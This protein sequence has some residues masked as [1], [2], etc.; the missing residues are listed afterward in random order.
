MCTFL[1]IRIKISNDNARNRRRK[2]PTQPSTYLYTF[3]GAECGRTR[4]ITMRKDFSSIMV[5]L[6]TRLSLKSS[7]YPRSILPS[8]SKHPRA[9]T[10]NEPTLPLPKRDEK[11]NTTKNE[12]RVARN[13][14]KPINI[15]QENDAHLS[16]SFCIR[17]F[18]SDHV[19]QCFVSHGL[20]RRSRTP[21]QVLIIIER[22]RDAKKN[23]RERAPRAR[24][25]SSP[26][27]HPREPGSAGLCLSPGISEV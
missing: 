19:C 16:H 22:K 2:S 23:T 5:I 17:A 21:F 18:S 13:P 12:M 6:W 11:Q 14:K 27:L 9:C 10:K 20:R 7:P 25:V 15:F 1:L 3:H 8:S 26:S 24:I 4:L